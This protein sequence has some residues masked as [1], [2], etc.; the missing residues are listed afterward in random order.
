MRPSI[1]IDFDGVIHKYSE[2]WKDGSIYDDP[3]P[4][5][6][7]ALRLLQEK[8]HIIIYSTRNHDRVVR[9]EHQKNQLKEVKEWL[10]KYDIPYDHIQAD[11]GKPL[12]KLFID[13]NAYRFEGDWSKALTEIDKLI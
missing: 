6:R 4:G 2:G 10:T 1:A 12:C 13:D 3:I 8:Y 9:G 5:V 11:P 7:D